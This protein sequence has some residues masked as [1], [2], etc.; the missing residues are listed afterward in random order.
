MSQNLEFELQDLALKL[1]R[2]QRLA[3]HNQATVDK[4]VRAFTDKGHKIETVGDIVKLIPD[5]PK[6]QKD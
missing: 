4:I 1:T 3:D 5:V 6:K 2:A